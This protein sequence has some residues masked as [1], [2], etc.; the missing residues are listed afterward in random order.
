MSLAK[1]SSRADQ[2]NRHAKELREILMQERDIYFNRTN[3]NQQISI[4]IETRVFWH[5]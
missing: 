3:E 1:Q 2:N 4:D 5:N